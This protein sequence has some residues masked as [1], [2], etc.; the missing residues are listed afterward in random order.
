MASRLLLIRH[1]ATAPGTRGLFVGATDV[2]ATREA[3]ADLDRLR[4]RLQV[5]RPD[6]WFVSPMTRALQTVH[7]L[8]DTN[9]VEFHIDERL[10]EIDFGR[11]EMK[12]FDEIAGTDPELVAAWSASYDSFVFPDGEGVADF[13]R[14]VRDVFSALRRL[15]VKEVAVVTHGGV[16][17]AMICQGLGLSPRNYLLFD[18]R[19]G[20]LT[21]L[22]MYQGGGGVL[23]G[24][25]I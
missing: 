16:I 5:H 3:L 7:R 15:P 11:W 4:D 21:V 9:A 1:A 20:T 2:E 8:H 6:S 19:P 12:R 10:R 22:D 24:L 14:R 25:S 17:R 13:Q 18:V 23:R